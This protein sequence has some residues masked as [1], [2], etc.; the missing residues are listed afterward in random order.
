MDSAC[1]TDP[2]Y[3]QLDELLTARNEAAVTA[4]LSTDDLDFLLRSMDF[5]EIEAKV[6]AKLRQIDIMLDAIAGP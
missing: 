5:N 3:E 1:Y 4:M 2:L 6:Q